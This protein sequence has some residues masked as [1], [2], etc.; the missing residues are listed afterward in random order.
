[1]EKHS[2]N[3]P[4]VFAETGLPGSPIA[5]YR[6]KARPGMRYQV[7][8]WC[9]TLTLAIVL[10]T[11]SCWELYSLSL[12]PTDFS[13]SLIL[14]S[15]YLFFAA[16][17]IFLFICMGKLI[18]ILWKLQHSIWQLQIYELGFAYIQGKKNR[19]VRWSEIAAIRCTMSQRSAIYG[20]PIALNSRAFTLP[21]CILRT[22]QGKI[23]KFDNTFQRTDPIVEDA[24]D[25]DTCVNYLEK[26]V[27]RH[28][29]P[30][31][32]AAYTSGQQITFGKLKIT[33]EGIGQGKVFL[34]WSLVAHAALQ[35]VEFAEGVPLTSQ[36]VLPDLV[37]YQQGEA[38]KAWYPAPVS[39]IP[40]AALFVALVEYILE[41]S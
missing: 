5:I 16:V 22:H 14:V 15:L 13:S 19:V 30:A 17:E 6:F 24:A 29:L 36:D 34:P 9:S 35:P 23:Y 12:R 27:T 26:E 25:V 28:L 20:L 31:A 2:L 33:N 18:R 41:H 11:G 7:Y 3:T 32:I 8:L 21:F 1:M 10:T 39:K 40:N 38:N 37:I 4:L